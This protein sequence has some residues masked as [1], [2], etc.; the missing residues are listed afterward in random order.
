MSEQ[1]GGSPNETSSRLGSL[2]GLGVM[3]YLAL[4]HWKIFL[5]FTGSYLADRIPSEHVWWAVIL[6]AIFAFAVG[7]TLIHASIEHFIK[8]RMIRGLLGR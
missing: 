2:I 3:G 4:N 5:S 7:V 6:V 8:L 1:N